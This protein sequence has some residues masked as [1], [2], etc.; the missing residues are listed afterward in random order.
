MYW[1]ARLESICG[2]G[3]E[4]GGALSPAGAAAG[5]RAGELAPAFAVSAGVDDDPLLQA[6]VTSMNTSRG[7]R[8]L[9][10]GG[11]RGTRELVPELCIVLR[12]AS[13]CMV[14]PVI[15]VVKTF[16]SLDASSAV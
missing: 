10:H 5:C 16:S 9:N 12:I 3:P 15:P 13:G 7:G 4:S 8:K 11:H 2:S 6:V 14:F 1:N